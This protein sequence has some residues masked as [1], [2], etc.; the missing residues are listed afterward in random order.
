[1]CTLYLYYP[2]LL[3]E[4]PLLLSHF[5]NLPVIE[6]FRKRHYQ[7]IAPYTEL[8]RNPVSHIF[9]TPSMAQWKESW[10]YFHLEDN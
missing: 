5:R 3:P 1:M 6:M 9:Q 7:F 8:E 10:L 4:R 2:E